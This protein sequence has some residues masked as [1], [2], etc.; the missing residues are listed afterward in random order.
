MMAFLEE[1]VVCIAISLGVRA[2]TS[3]AAGLFVPGEAAKPERP[4]ICSR[5]GEAV[6]AGAPLHQHESGKAFSE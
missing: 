3:V 4:Q 5:C 2:V 1:L 6:S